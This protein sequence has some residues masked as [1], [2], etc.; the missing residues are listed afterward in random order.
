MAENGISRSRIIQERPVATAQAVTRGVERARN[1]PI[2]RCA[3]LDEYGV[4]SEAEYKRRNVA[5]GRIML[6][7]QIGWRDPAKSRRGWRE[8]YEAINKAGGRLDRYGICLD[9]SM[10]YP[11]HMREGRP[12]GTGLILG[13]PEDFAAL[14]AEAPVAPHFG[15]FVLG[16]PAAVENTQAALYAGATSIGNM[17]QYFTFRMP[18]WD[19]DLATTEATVEALA[20]IAAQPVE[21]MVHSNLDDGFAPLFTDMAC[22]LG[23]ALL[24]RYIVEELLGGYV[25][26]CYGHTFSEPLTRLAFQRALAKDR[27]DRPG[28]M[29]YGNTVLYDGSGPENYAALT[30]YLMIDIAAQQLLPSGHAVNPV[31]ITEAERIP[32]IDEAIEAALVALRLIERAEEFARI[33]DVAAADRVAGELLR[34]GEMFRDRVLAGLAEA[35][36]DIDNAGEVMLA[37]R[38]IGPKMLERLFGPGVEDPGLLNGRAPT[39]PATAIRALERAADKLV[40]RIEPAEREEIRAAKLSVCLSATDVHEYGKILIG[41]TLARLGVS[42]IDAGV[43]AE[44]DD[45][46][47]LARDRGA[48]FVAVSTYNG[49]ALGYLKALQRALAAAD[50]TAPVLIGGRLNQLPEASN[51]SLPVDVSDRLAETGALVCGRAEDMFAP[52]LEAARD[53]E[54]KP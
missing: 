22:S 42:V 2:G 17:G 52:L 12:K 28:T 53:R 13:G 37:L 14:T 43:H 31:P 23:A 18:G 9:W 49:V 36:F 48:D 45:V 20:L 54:A 15:D 33:V 16:M 21:I 10:G 35:G 1:A 50:V 6:H 24:E 41:E 46:A 5:D 44:P 4:S 39:V 11:A 19:D 25:G 30:S 26:H 3:F 32:D 34:G 7:G 47:A 29:V 40:A 51:T 38:R 8:F 27:E